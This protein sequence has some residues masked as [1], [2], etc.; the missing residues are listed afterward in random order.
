MSE[1]RAGRRHW[2]SSDPEIRGTYRESRG[3]HLPPR[4]NAVGPMSET[5]A[6][7]YQRPQTSVNDPPLETDSGI[8]QAG[9]CVI[10]DAAT[11]E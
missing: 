4:W 1:L 11:R 3:R 6:R 8:R 9:D 2:S 5:V 10:P 7:S